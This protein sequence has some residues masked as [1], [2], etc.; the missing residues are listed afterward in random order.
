MSYGDIATWI[1]TSHVTFAIA[2]GVGGFL[3]DVLHK[4]YIEF[5]SRIQVSGHQGMTIG[6]LAA[7]IS[8]LF[9]GIIADNSWVFSFLAG[10]GLG[11]I[12]TGGATIIR[13]S[14]GTTA[15]KEEKIVCSSDGNANGNK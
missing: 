3:S 9:A 1:L 7:F 8:G 14:N 11:A 2:G 5:P 15:V 13:K 12:V 6:F 10:A 4:G